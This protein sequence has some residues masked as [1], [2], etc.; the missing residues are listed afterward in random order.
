MEGLGPLAPFILNHDGMVLLLILMSKLG[1]M[2][3]EQM[4]GLS[5]KRRRKS[6]EIRQG[7]VGGRE[8]RICKPK[9]GKQSPP[10][11]LPQQNFA[12]AVAAAAL[13]DSHEPLSQPALQSAH[14]PLCA[15][16]SHLTFAHFELV[17]FEGNLS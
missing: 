3:W 2:D 5:R 4:K 1:W 14:G 11:P 7:G 12:P 13:S 8:A 17:G 15:S 10:L 9:R 6:S 16:V